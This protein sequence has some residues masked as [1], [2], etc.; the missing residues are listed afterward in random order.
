LPTAG[1]ILAE[2]PATGRPRNLLATRA[3]I[4]HAQ[5]KN[6]KA[7]EKELPGRPYSAPAVARPEFC[8]HS[9]HEDPK[10]LVPYC[11]ARSKPTR[12]NRRENLEIGDFLRI[13]EPLQTRKPDLQLFLYGASRTARLEALHYRN[14]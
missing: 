14:Q 3:K 4:A 6:I 1:R 5:P 13:S 9:L 11:E 10:L 7:F 8:Y 12:Q 2:T